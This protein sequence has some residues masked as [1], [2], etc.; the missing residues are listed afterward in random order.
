MLAVGGAGFVYVRSE[1]VLKR[2]YD[3]PLAPLAVSTDSV[4]IAEGHRLARVLGCFNGCHGVTVEGSEFFNERGVARLVASNLTQVRHDYTDEQF[5]RLL[6]RGV[7]NDGRSVFAMPSDAFSG[8]SDRDVGRLVAFI[9]SLPDTDGLERAF[10][11]GPLGRLGLAM[12]EFRPMAPTL[13]HDPRAVP[14]PQAGDTLEL[15]R[16]LARV[17]CAE[18]HGLGLNGRDLAPAL[19]IVAGYSRANFARLLDTGVPADG[20]DLSLMDDVAPKRFSHLTDEEVEGLYRYLGT[21]ATQT[22]PAPGAP[23]DPS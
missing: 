14:T 13:D 10:E 3:V 16:Y 4:S 21:L 12:G 9:R 6:R 7:L 1:R 22:S 2:T 19:T 23:R 17:A 5:E 15:G 8:L 18:C 11:V 20:R